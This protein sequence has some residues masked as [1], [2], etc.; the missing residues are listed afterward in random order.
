MCKGK[1]NFHAHEQEESGDKRKR[2]WEKNRRN[3]R[4]SDVCTLILM[5]KW[6]YIF[7]IAKICFFIELFNVLQ[8]TKL[9]FFLYDKDL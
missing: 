3:F 5:I 8:I 9:S 4:I 7:V 6:K 2:R 1:I